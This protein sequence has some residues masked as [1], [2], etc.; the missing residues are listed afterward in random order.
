MG[1]E[2]LHP[3]QLHDV[4]HDDFLVAG[5]VGVAHME[6]FS[7][8]RNEKA[9]VVQALHALYAPELGLLAQGGVVFCVGRNAVGH[10]PQH[11]RRA[12]GD[13][14]QYKPA[15]V[16]QLQ[17]E[18]LP[19]VAVHHAPGQI[20][21]LPG[22]NVRVLRHDKGHQEVGIV[23]DEAAD[24]RQAPQ[25]FIDRFQQ[26]R[27]RRPGP[28]LDQLDVEQVHRGHHVIAARLQRTPAQH[29]LVH[30]AQEHPHRQIN[31]QPEE[32]HEHQKYIL[33]V[34]RGMHRRADHGDQIAGADVVHHRGQHAPLP[35]E[36]GPGAGGLLQQLD[37]LRSL[38]FAGLD[39]VLDHIVDD[40]P[41][42]AAV[43]ADALEGYLDLATSQNLIP[44]LGIGQHVVEFGPYE[45]GQGAKQGQQHI[46]A[47]YGTPCPQP[48]MLQI[49]H[50]IVS[51]NA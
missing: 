37:A 9:F 15:Q 36:H 43:A 29:R 2:V 32:H 31:G 26:Q 44:G 22:A 34:E 7:I 21:G 48:N 35:S 25:R 10:A 39:V 27:Q 38:Q 33:G 50:R 24:D 20:D 1:K 3:G 5:D 41:P 30:V 14:A 4:L 47:L 18:A 12:E 51:L 6:R 8:R 13:K 42:H 40:P 49:N 45:Y 17:Q 46:V 16:G 23:L 28:A 11:I 19:L